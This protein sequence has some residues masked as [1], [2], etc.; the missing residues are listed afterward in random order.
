MIV[1]DQ[2]DR[3][4]ES[5]ELAAQRCQRKSSDITLVAVSKKQPIELIQQYVE[6]AHER[7]RE[8]VL[9]ENYV[10]ELKAKRALFP[11]SVRFH[12]LGP[13]QSNKIRDAVRCADVIQSVHSQAVLK[14]VA[15]EAAK[16]GVQRSIFL[17]VNIGN[18]PLKS[19]FD[20]EQ[21]A[22]FLEAIAVDMPRSLRILG[23]MT[24]TPY[25]EEPEHAR[26][27]FER[28]RRLRDTLLSQG[29]GP[30]FAHTTPLLSMGMSADFHVA[31]E[32][33]ADL[34]RVGT[35]IFGERP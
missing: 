21:L 23:L 9:G 27:D 24:I 30:C 20:A 6:A 1:A 16:Q 14:G 35:A 26:P 13:L 11:E 34:V 5:I 22:Y 4:L 7:G 10:Q 19:G 29:L 2:L 3:V 15:D 32:E 12:Q 28:M 33:G 25:F 8:V 18:D 17:Q 31:I